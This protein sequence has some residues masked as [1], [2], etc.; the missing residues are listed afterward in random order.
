MRWF[1]YLVLVGFMSLTLSGFGQTTVSPYSSKGLGELVYP[2]MPHNIAMGEIGIASPSYWSINTVNPALLANNQ[3]TTFQVGFQGDYR[4]FVSDSTSQSDGTASLRLLNLAFPIKPRRWATSVSLTPYSTVNYDFFENLQI[5]DTEAEAIQA[6]EGEGGL[7]RLDWAHGVRITGRFLLGVK[8]TY[9]FGSIRKSA[10]SI[11]V[12]DET[13]FSIF[14]NERES[15]RDFTI[16]FGAFYKWALADNKGINFG[17]TYTPATSLKGTKD[18]TFTRVSAGTTFATQEINEGVEISY[19]LPTEIGFGIA[20]E[21]LNRLMIGVDFTMANGGLYEADPENYRE[22]MRLSA[23]LEFI[24]DYNSVTSYF[25]RLAYRAGFSLVQ[26]PYLVQGQVIND[27]GVSFGSAFPI[28]GVSSL[29]TAI[30]FGWRGTT[31]DG[32][33]RENYVQMVFG[34]T[35]N[36]R[37]FIKRRYD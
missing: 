18:E 35:I 11:V 13:P 1:R 23:G 6:F 26:S 5:E 24:P 3:L 9:I 19:D 12:G 25:D 15:Y 28:G 33:I 22:T 31:A 36:D 21:D 37:W 17:A 30:K 7:S 27:F 10:R 14:Y 16:Q 32:L 20:Y 2:G 34:L 29:D 8:A 4:T